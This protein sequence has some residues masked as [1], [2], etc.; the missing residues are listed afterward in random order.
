M[1]DFDDML[2]GP[3]FKKDNAEGEN[4]QAE[5]K[6]PLDIL[7][8][9]KIPP[10]IL[11]LALKVIAVIAVIAVQAA[12][13]YLIVTQV[14]SPFTPEEAVKPS[15]EPAD[16][17]TTA[18][19]D[20]VQKDTQGGP[21]GIQQEETKENDE[22]LDNISLLPEPDL[23]QPNVPPK[24]VGSIFTL[25]DVVVNPAMSQGRRFFIVTAVI[26]FEEKKMDQLATEREPI[27]RDGYIRIMSRKSV[28]WLSSYSNQDVLKKELMTYTK[29]V[30][31]Y[32][33]DMYMAF[34]KYVLQ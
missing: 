34:T 11:K 25:S 16:S 24:E 26:I 28:R 7:K 15:V 18:S 2:G 27:L 4:S 9:I 1:A 17:L 3:E 5:K 31:E 8:R 30:L 22:P 10:S 14:I 13:S 29:Q 32:T 23:N 20:V 19:A 33:G 21:S 6:S 12:A